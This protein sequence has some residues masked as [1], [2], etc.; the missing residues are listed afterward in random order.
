M[1]D[2]VLSFPSWLPTPTPNGYQILQAPCEL[3]TTLR[4]S[5]IINAR[6]R[7]RGQKVFNVRYLMN[8]FEYFNFIVFYSDTDFG[9]LP[10]TVNLL[11]GSGF[12][13]FTVK[14]TGVPAFDYRD[15]NYV[16]V[17]CSYSEV[18]A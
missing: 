7:A 15:G 3:I 16:E 2:S 1:T 12:R 18:L 14:F 6:I 10:F 4:T 9:V 8:E 13:Q 17:A 5:G 11:I